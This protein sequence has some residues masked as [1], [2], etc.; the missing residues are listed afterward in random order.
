MYYIYTGSPTKLLWP[1]SLALTLTR[2][3]IATACFFSLSSPYLQGLKA[4]SFMYLIRTVIIQFTVL[5]GQS[6]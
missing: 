4:A 3:P 6:I 5:P 1:F 2:L